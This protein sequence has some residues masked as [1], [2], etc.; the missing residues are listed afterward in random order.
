VDVAAAIPLPETLLIFSQIASTP[1][2][3][4][5]VRFLSLYESPYS[6][7]PIV[8]FLSQLAS[9]FPNAPSAQKYHLISII[10][11]FIDET[12]LKLLSRAPDASIRLNILQACPEIY[13]ER[14]LDCGPRVRLEAVRLC[15]LRETKP[16]S[17]LYRLFE[18]NENHSSFSLPVLEQ[19]ICFSF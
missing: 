19:V 2:S 10:Q 16:H 7:S 5:S 14:L 17:Q 6:P 1:M 11:P 12:C 8:P 15:A 9:Y 4:P 18:L 13:H 3:L